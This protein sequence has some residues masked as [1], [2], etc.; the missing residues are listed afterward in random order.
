MCASVGSGANSSTRRQAT[1]TN[2]QSPTDQGGSATINDGATPGFPGDDVIDYDPPAGYAG[3]D[4]FTYAI[5]DGF[6]GSDSATVTMTVSTP[7]PW[8]DPDQSYA[9]FDGDRIVWSAA[10]QASGYHLYR[11]DLAV[12]RSGGSFAQ[13]PASSSLAERV[14]WLTD[15]SYQD[16]FVPP[17]GETVF[18]L[19][20]MDNGTSEESLGSDSDGVTRP[21]D[22]PCR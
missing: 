7:A 17:A 21:N 11:G 12:V 6:G 1:I 18:Y 14:C 22:Y 13:D 5:D 15:T 16:G 10:Q 9:S 4:T 19:V 20:T 2:A 8:T 3:I